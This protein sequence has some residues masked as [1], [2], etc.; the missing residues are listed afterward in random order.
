LSAP[1]T[2]AATLR[3][4]TS[5]L[6]TWTCAS[7]LAT[8][9]GEQVYANRGVTALVQVNGA[10][11]YPGPLP[12]PQDGGITVAGFSLAVGAFVPGQVNF[13]LGGQLSAGGAAAA[14]QYEGDVG[15]WTLPALYPDLN[16]PGQIDFGTTVSFSPSIADIDYGDGGPQFLIE[17]IDA[18]G[19]VGPPLS[20]P[21]QRQA[22]APVAH[23]S[24]SLNW[25]AQ[26][27]LDLH[28]VEPDGTEIWRQHRS[29][30]VPNEIKPLPVNLIAFIHARHAYLDFDSN[31][32][33]VIDGRRVEN[34]IWGPDAGIQSGTYTVLVDTFS[35]CGQAFAHWQ[36][37]AY[38]DG[39]QIAAGTGESLQSDEAYFDHG[40]GAGLTAFTFQVP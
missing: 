24:I 13:P 39:G 25:D 2:G 20:V 4:P 10:Q 5:L 23:L 31:A 26:A 36:V 9:C 21:I 28:V 16:V 27:D 34:V 14:I 35:M 30:Y 29:D 22:G 8:A 7:L 11:F 12:T 40:A 3:C 33:C 1:P 32:Q 17:A 37:G 15:Y 18:D 19:G 6:S 38:V